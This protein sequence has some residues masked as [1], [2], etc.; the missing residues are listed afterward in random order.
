MPEKSRGRKAAKAAGGRMEVVSKKNVSFEAEQM[1]IDEK[2]EE[3][4]KPMYKGKRLDDPI[5]SPVVC[6]MRSYRSNCRINGSYYQHFSRSK[7][8]S[9]NM[10]IRSIILSTSI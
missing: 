1:D 5:A 2:F 4:K 6:S 7:D 3:L 9:N 10:S 8:L